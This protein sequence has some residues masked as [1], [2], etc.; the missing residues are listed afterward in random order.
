MPNRS[1][2]RG[3]GWVLCTS[4]NV[5]SSGQ[6][7]LKGLPSPQQRSW[8][9]TL[10]AAQSLS[11]SPWCLCRSQ[12]H[13]ASTYSTSPNSDKSKC[14]ITTCRLQLIYI[15]R[16]THTMHSLSHILF[17]CLSLQVIISFFP[18]KIIVTLHLPP[19]ISASDTFLSSQNEICFILVSTPGQGSA[20]NGNLMY[21]WRAHSHVIAFSFSHR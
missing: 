8:W 14:F 17:E 7:R 3:W 2:T 11:A 1:L 20:V 10:T 5:V 19:D 13:Q 16:H 9:R 18:I 4:M 15:R 6:K 12:C 21:R